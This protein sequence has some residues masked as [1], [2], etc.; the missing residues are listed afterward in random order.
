MYGFQGNEKPPFP[1]GNYFASLL[2][3]A[4]DNIVYQINGLTGDTLAGG[5]ENRL[6]AHLNS[7][8]VVHYDQ[9]VILGGANDIIQATRGNRSYINNLGPALSSLTRLSLPRSTR[10]LF[11]PTFESP[12]FNDPGLCASCVKEF[13]EFKSNFFAFGSKLMDEYPDQVFFAD[14]TPMILNLNRKTFFIDQLHLNPTGNF[15]LAQGLVKT[16]VNIRNHSPTCNMNLR[17][18]CGFAGISETQCTNVGCCWKPVNPNPSK[19]P[20]CFLKT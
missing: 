4:G 5:F 7:S 3:D 15:A 17:V 18:D 19:S 12:L 9:I 10:L 1:F 2:S 14:S 11:L 13:R 16:L 6:K 8:Q 20:W